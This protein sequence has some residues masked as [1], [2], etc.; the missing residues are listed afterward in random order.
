MS[1]TLELDAARRRTVA[2]VEAI[3]SE[4]ERRDT[5]EQTAATAGLERSLSELRRLTTV[6]AH[7]G[8]SS[9]WPVLGRFEVL[10]KRSMRIL[11]RWY[12]NPLVEQQN[13]YNLAVLAS[14]YEIEAQLHAISRDLHHEKANA[15]TDGAR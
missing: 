10:A 8:I 12:I 7:W 15:P 2:A 5:R 3:R 14:L 9:S 13:D 11:L 1:S 6:N 4:L